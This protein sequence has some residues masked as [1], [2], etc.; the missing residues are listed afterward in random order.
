MLLDKIYYT[1]N[2]LEGDI[3]EKRGRYIGR[4]EMCGACTPASRNRGGFKTCL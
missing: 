4:A 1:V 2:S 3:S